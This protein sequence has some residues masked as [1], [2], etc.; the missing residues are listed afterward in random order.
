[1]D[2][3][4]YA[5]WPCRFC[6]HHPLSMYYPEGNFW[7]KSVMP[8]CRFKFRLDR[9]STNDTLEVDFANK[10]IGGDALHKG[11][12]QRAQGAL[13]VAIPPYED[14]VGR[15]GPPRGGPPRGGADRAVMRQVMGRREKR[16]MG[17]RA[18]MIV[19]YGQSNSTGSKC[20]RER[21]RERER[22]LGQNLTWR[23]I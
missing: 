5:C 21:E 10:Y 20:R 3:L 19:D 6:D 12:V 23:I 13:R 2:I 11:C 22:G 17:R 16:E 8:L 15:G 9:R 18:M 14:E 7:S 4:M 1:M